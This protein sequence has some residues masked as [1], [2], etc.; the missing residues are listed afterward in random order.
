MSVDLVAVLSECLR[1]YQ[2]ATVWQTVLET[3]CCADYESC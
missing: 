2:P 3:A 1:H